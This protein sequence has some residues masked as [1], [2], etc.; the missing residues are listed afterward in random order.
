MVPSGKRFSPVEISLCRRWDA[1]HP[2]IAVQSAIR[3]AFPD[4]EQM[5]PPID[6]YILAKRRGIKQVSIRDIETDGV[7]SKTSNGNYIVE[8]NAAH[9][10]TRRRFTLA[11]EIGHTF[12]FDLL[13]T[14]GNRYRAADCAEASFH[15]DLSEEDLCNVA[16]SEILMPRTQFMSGLKKYGPTAWA[17]CPII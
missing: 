6:P 17:G 7:M 14:E 9:P 8:L 13:P 2:L 5:T 4:L 1:R 12:F 3:A 15:R 16:A 11:H 10:E